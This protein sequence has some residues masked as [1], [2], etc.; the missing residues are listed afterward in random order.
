MGILV[1][2]QFGNKF[3]V[4]YADGDDEWGVF[5]DE[6]T[7]FDLVDGGRRRVEWFDLSSRDLKAAGTNQEAN[8][9]TESAQGMARQRRGSNEERGGQLPDDASQ[10]LPSSRASQKKPQKQGAFTSAFILSSGLDPVEPSS[11]PDTSVDVRRSRQQSKKL[12]KKKPASKRNR[13]SSGPHGSDLDRV[14]KF[15]C[16]DWWS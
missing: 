5:Q 14:L 11:A 7:A 16:R 3:R 12:V 13:E 2:Y 6:F 9:P 1:E 15:V 4:A 10:R 8:P